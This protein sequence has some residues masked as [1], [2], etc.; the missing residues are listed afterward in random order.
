M[1][2]QDYFK[3]TVK[4]IF[5]KNKNYTSK[6][7]EKLDEI[8]N[9]L[10]SKITNTIGKDEMY[11][12]YVSEWRNDNGEIYFKCMGE[13]VLGDMEDW[14]IQMMHLVKQRYIELYR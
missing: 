6:I 12:K 13:H 14:E 4:D 1:E 3:T 8:N 11:Q 2:M 5:D 9:E 7:S 10:G